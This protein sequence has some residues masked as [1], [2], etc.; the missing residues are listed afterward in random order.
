M[1]PPD[2]GGARLCE[3]WSTGDRRRQWIVAARWL[4]VGL[5]ARVRPE[6]DPPASKLR[7]W[8]PA[9]SSTQSTGWE[10]RLPTVGATGA[11]RR[12]VRPFQK[13]GQQFIVAFHVVQR[14]Y[15]TA[16]D[17]EMLQI[18]PA[19][20]HFI[21]ATNCKTTS[22]GANVQHH[23]CRMKIVLRRIQ[24]VVERFVFPNG[25]VGIPVIGRT[26]LVRPTCPRV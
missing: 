19:S 15:D 4:L 17:L 24:D 22:N 3:D 25:N 20:E 8:G 6:L 10:N 16:L 13:A 2:Q 11:R 1:W 7:D 9:S 12:C 26:I 14:M 18:A 5:F 21:D 23:V